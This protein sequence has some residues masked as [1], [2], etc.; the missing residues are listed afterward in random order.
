MDDKCQQ[1]SKYPPLSKKLV[2]ISDPITGEITYDSPDGMT[3]SE[4]LGCLEFAK[5]LVYDEMRKETE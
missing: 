4:A 3:Y 5:F 2:I 1:A